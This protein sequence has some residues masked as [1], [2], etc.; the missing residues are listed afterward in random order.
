MYRWTKKKFIF[1][2]GGD[3]HQ[4]LPVV[5]GGSKT[6]IIKACIKSSP[7]W[8]QFHQIKL[9]ENMRVNGLLKTLTSESTVHE[10]IFVEEQRQYADFLVDLSQNRASKSLNVI[11]SKLSNHIVVV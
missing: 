3:F 11:H 10:R 9:A 1:V 2:C 4:I 7:Y 5:Q 8:S 6:E